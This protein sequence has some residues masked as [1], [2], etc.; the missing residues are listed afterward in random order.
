MKQ[1]FFILNFGESD[2]ISFLEGKYMMHSTAKLISMGK[3]K[4][5]KKY[6]AQKYLNK[7]GLLTDQEYEELCAKAN[8]S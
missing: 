1:V 8:F 3:K 6:V 2:F 4:W 7:S 5:V